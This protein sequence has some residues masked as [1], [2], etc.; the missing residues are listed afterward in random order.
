MYRFQIRF[1]TPMYNNSGRG[2]TPWSPTLFPRLLPPTI[3]ASPGCG[4]LLHCFAF[5]TIVWVSW[6]RIKTPQ[7]FS[8]RRIVR[9]DE[10]AH[11]VFSAPVSNN[12][13]SVHDPW[14]ACYRIGLIRRSCFNAQAIVPSPALGL[15]TFH[16]LSQR[17]F[18]LPRRDSP[19]D[20]IAAS[21]SSPGSR[22]FRS[23]L[24][25]SPV[26]AS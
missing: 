10:A 20:H 25:D 2:H 1:P 4:G 17:I 18:F 24:Q 12:H 22:H 7:L 11:S 26:R 13:L 3:S 5:E 21:V 6:H 19:I 9:R 14:C 23:N 16:Q 15:S 8:A